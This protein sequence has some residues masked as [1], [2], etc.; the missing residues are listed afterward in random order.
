MMNEILETHGR[1]LAGLSDDKRLNPYR[2]LASSVIERAFHD[3]EQKTCSPE[4]SLAARR[5]LSGDS[6]L[7]RLWCRWLNIH[8]DRI[9]A[10]AASRGWGDSQGRGSRPES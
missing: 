3:A 5:F 9:R 4:D 2:R 8:P 1:I 6:W 10:E 7:L